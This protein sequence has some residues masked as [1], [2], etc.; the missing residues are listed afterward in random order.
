MTRLQ[1]KFYCQSTLEVAK[2]L[3]GKKIVIQKP[4]YLEARIIETEA[5]LGPQDKAAHTCNGKTKR[6]QIVW[7]S[8]GCLYVYLIYGMYWML[9][10]TT[11]ARDLPQCVLIR[12]VDAKGVSLDKTNGPGKTARFLGIDQS[13]YG[14]SLITS[15]RIGVIDARALPDKNIITGPRVNIDYAGTPWTKKRWRFYIKQYASKLP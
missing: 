10:I 3:L 7:G 5:Y 8:P 15:K 4:N 6:N 13:F 14:E 2:Q 12:A 11:D 1:E 9:N